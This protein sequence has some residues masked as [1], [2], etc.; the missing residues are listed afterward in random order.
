MKSRNS[1]KLCS[2]LLALAL[3]LTSSLTLG[4]SAQDTQPDANDTTQPVDPTP[5]GN[6]QDTPEGDAGAND[7]TGTA[8]D[9]GEGG[10]AGD[11]PAPPEQEEILTDE[12]GIAYVLGDDGQSYVVKSYYGSLTE[13]VI[14]ATYH[15]LPVTAIDD[16]AFGISNVES[17][18]IPGSVKSIGAYA[19]YSCDQLSSLVIPEGVT[20]IGAYAFC[21]CE[22]LTDISIPNTMTDIG[23]HA[24]DD[25]ESLGFHTY[26][27][28][29]YLGNESNPYHALVLAPAEVTGS[30]TIHEDTRI[31]LC[32]AFDSC[33]GL[34]SVE[35]PSGVVKI[36]EGAFYA[37]MELTTL[38]VAEGNTA[39]AVT[40]G[41]LIELDSQTL[42]LGTPDSVIPTDGSI[43]RIGAYAFFCNSAIT[44]ITLPEGVESI[45]IRAFSGCVVETVHLPA[46][47]TEIGEL[48]FKGIDFLTS[49]TVDAENSAYTVVGNCL[50]ESKSGTLLLGYGS[51]EIPADGSVTSIG[52]SAFSENYEIE[53]VVIPEGVTHVGD[54]AFA[55]CM[56]LASVT[57]PE[58]LNVIGM[59]AFASTAITE[60]VI[61]AKVKSVDLMAFFCSELQSITFLSPHADIDQSANTI[62]ASATIHGYMGSTAQTYAEMNGR[63]FEALEPE[64]E[65]EPEQPDL[66]LGTEGLVYTLNA[67]GTQYSVTGY[68]GTDVHVI[69]PE[70][71]AGLPVVRVTKSAFATNSQGGGGTVELPPDILVP[72]GMQ[73][74]PTNATT[75]TA[76]TDGVT[77]QS[78]TLLS[79]T[80]ILEDSKN[81]IP[82]GVAIYGYL[83]S[84]AEKYATKYNRTFAALDGLSFVLTN[85]GASYMLESYLGNQAKV[86]LPATYL[87]LPVTAIGEGAF[88]WSEVSEVVLPNSILSIGDN[89]FYQ[90]ALKS[91]TV[92]ASVTFIG[93]CAFNNDSMESMVVEDGNAVYY[94]AQNCIIETATST[95]IAGCKTSVIPANGNVTVIGGGAFA[96]IP[97]TSIAIPDAITTIMGNAFAE[98]ADLESVTF[99]SDS[100]LTSIG[101][102][103]F[104]ENCSL[105]EFV[106]P[107]SLVEIGYGAFYCCCGLEQIT[108]GAAVESVGEQAFADCDSLT[109]ITVRSDS[110]D[111]FDAEDTLPETAVIHGHAGS[112]AQAYAEKYGREFVELAPYTPGDIDGVEGVSMD[113]AIYLLFYTIFP[114]QYPVEQ[115]CDYNHDSVV[116]MDDAIYLLFYTIFPAQYPL[117]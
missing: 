49:F 79:S 93:T 58:S 40:D 116:T 62:S 85:E 111:I 33:Y 5:P 61:P 23:E 100:Q 80:V 46:S 54:S 102:C 75:T 114:S 42:L 104:W 18:E 105:T 48:A 82:S 55:N 25:C 98:C 63:V 51:F 60:I 39:Y 28:S 31:I 99:G 29:L 56:N 38:T 17:V 108:L 66:T 15:D 36:A 86:T 115:P 89:A 97:L 6:A 95:L 88:A 20:S 26:E 13:L 43:K 84:T 24:F 53:S 16:W 57:L 37:C 67:A 52:D 2:V 7:N 30:L 101:A 68:E 9:Q 32:Y 27:G 73:A 11:T 76:T 41:C 70:V 1:R 59:N 81:T 64:P 106:L 44:E 65:P 10:N 69:V 34:E 117:T 92:P 4:V 87:G 14:P 110:V 107:A 47:V 96:R 83:G 45:G 113:D 112:A 35:I 71:Y 22:A 19:F 109:K 94:S 8:P 12:Q 21:G 50:I 103:A 91:I 3:L 72:R 90:S 77:L 74:A 78:I